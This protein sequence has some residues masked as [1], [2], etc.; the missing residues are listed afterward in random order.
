MLNKFDFAFNPKDEG[1]N[2]CV[3]CRSRNGS[4]QKTLGVDS[5]KALL[6]TIIIDRAYER[7]ND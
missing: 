6:F 7:F 4:G 2:A 3:L 5:E 1:G